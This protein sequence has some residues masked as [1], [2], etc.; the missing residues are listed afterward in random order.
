MELQKIVLIADP[1]VLAI[2]IRENRE[3]MVNLRSF[4]DIHID[5]RKSESSKMFSYVRTS[6]AHKLLE[7]ER[8]LPYGIHLLIIEG[9]RP[10]SL[11]RKYFDDYSRELKELHPDWTDKTIYQ[12]ASKYVS[13]PEITPPH[14]TGGAI[15]LTLCDKNSTEF[16]MGT[17]VNADPEKSDGA[18]FTATKNILPKAREN[19]N[20]LIDAMI[21]HG[22][23]N[24]PTEWWHWSYGDRY[25]AYMAKQKHAIFGSIE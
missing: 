25:W 22:F 4:S 18:C 5:E 2:P 1:E 16:D 24:Y 10:L 23:V 12:E 21:C 15:D 9:H 14:S 20:I 7:V 17:W 6:L 3:E 8:S 13:P 19:R 11:Q